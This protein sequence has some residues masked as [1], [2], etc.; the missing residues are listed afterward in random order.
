MDGVLVFTVMN[1]GQNWGEQKYLFVKS[2][3]GRNY[4][5]DQKYRGHKNTTPGTKSI[6]VQ[7]IS[8]GTNYITLGT[9]NIIRGTI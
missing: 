7:K 6:T 4:C 8:L 1:I 3:C 2:H 5:G 9:K